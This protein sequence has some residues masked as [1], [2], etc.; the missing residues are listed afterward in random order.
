MTL[1]NFKRSGEIYVGGDLVGFT[2][3]SDDFKVG[4]HCTGQT[5]DGTTVGS[6]HLRDD[7]GAP[8]AT[9]TVI[10]DEHAIDIDGVASLED[11]EKFLT[12]AL[13]HVKSLRGR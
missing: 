10:A 4:K 2:E 11:W 1:G 7:L 3:S 5:Y 12:D 13:D 9:V 6:F 8:R